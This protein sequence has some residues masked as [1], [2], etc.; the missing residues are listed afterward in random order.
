MEKFNQRSS[1]IGLS[2]VFGT[3]Q[4]QS[5]GLPKHRSERREIEQHEWNRQK[6]GQE[7][8]DRLP[9]FCCTVADRQ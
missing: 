2:N 3:K 6:L 9:S 1:G 7:Q 5:Q 4:V 8:N